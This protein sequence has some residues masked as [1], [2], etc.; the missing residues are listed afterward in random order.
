MA[1]LVCLTALLLVCA[2][3]PN[4]QAQIQ[5]VRKADFPLCLNINDNPIIRPR[6][7][8]ND[9]RPRRMDDA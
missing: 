1:L 5:D 7:N 3:N 6:P 4:P 8:P 9:P 2:R